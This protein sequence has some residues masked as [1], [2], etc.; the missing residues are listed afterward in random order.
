[1]HLNGVPLTKGQ[2]N[3]DDQVR[4]EILIFW[5]VENMVSLTFSSKWQVSEASY[6]T[7]GLKYHHEL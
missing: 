7:H 3:I 4:K 6:R 5:K 1:M 2:N